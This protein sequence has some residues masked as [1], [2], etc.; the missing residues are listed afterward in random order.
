MRNRFSS[1]NKSQTL[2][3][4][5]E[6]KERYSSYTPSEIDQEY[7]TLKERYE[8]LKLFADLGKDLGNEYKTLKREADF[9]QTG[10]RRA[11]SEAINTLGVIGFIGHMFSSDPY[12]SEKHK[13]AVMAAESAKKRAAS[14]DT[15]LY[16]DEISERKKI[17]HELKV[18]REIR[19]KH[20]EM[21]IKSLAK[22]KVGKVRS[23]SATLKKK[24]LENLNANNECPYCSKTF[25]TKKMVLDHIYPVSEG[26]L[27]TL[28]NTVL[29]CISC[30]SKKSNLTLRMFSKKY[31]INFEKICEKLDALGK[32]Y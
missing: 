17:Y 16:A 28:K 1:L 6:I 8:E 21:R 2:L 26:G 30:N 31:E 15:N 29:V 11:R 23:S 18:L 13:S 10:A 32:K 25:E 3:L 12:V 19:K 5:K 9:A 7:E 4:H 24:T 27:D 14:V 20:N 22:S